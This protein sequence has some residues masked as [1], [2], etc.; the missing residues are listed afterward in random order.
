VFAAVARTCTHRREHRLAL[1]VLRVDDRVADDVLEENLEDP[2][3]LFV[4]QAGD[5]LYAPAARK[6]ADRRFGHACVIT[7]RSWSDETSGP[8]GCCWRLVC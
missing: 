6:A 7:W 5:P 8:G 1:G 3:R 4:A 2:A